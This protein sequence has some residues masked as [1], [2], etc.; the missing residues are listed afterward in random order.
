ML[1]VLCSYRISKRSAM[2]QKNKLEKEKDYHEQEGEA[3]KAEMIKRDISIVNAMISDLKFAIDWMETGR[4]PGTYRG[5]ERQSAYKRDIP[6]DNDVIS[7]IVG[8][9]VDDYAKDNQADR[10]E[11]ELKEDLVRDIQKCLTQK[12]IEVFAMLANGM[13]QA[14]I[15]KLLGTSRQAVHD[16][17]KR[18]RR[19]IKE[20][21]WIMV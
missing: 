15:A 13:T 7:I 17:I 14:E 18:G 21:G 4:Q 11:N 6:F 2:Q 10:E 16:T 19:S 8:G 3:E 5:A 9:D 20:E 1:D 12:Q